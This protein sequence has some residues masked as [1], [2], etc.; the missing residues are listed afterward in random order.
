MSQPRCSPGWKLSVMLLLFVSDNRKALGT[1]STRCD[2]NRHDKQT[3]R[4]F[5]IRII[6]IGIDHRVGCVALW[7][8]LWIWLWLGLG[9]ARDM[10]EMLYDCASAT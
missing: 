9:L 2:D 8:W 5:S 1:T 10:H 4:S 7:L 6:L 3:K